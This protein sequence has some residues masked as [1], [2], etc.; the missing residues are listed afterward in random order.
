MSSEGILSVTGWWPDRIPTGTQKMWTGGVAVQHS[1]TSSSMD[2]VPSSK[3]PETPTCSPGA[4]LQLAIA[5]GMPVCIC[6]PAPGWVKSREN[7]FPQKGKIKDYFNLTQVMFG[8][9]PDSL[10][11]GRSSPFGWTRAIVS[12][13]YLMRKRKHCRGVGS[14]RYGL[15]CTIMNNMGE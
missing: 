14:R 8:Y 13:L 11:E 9:K 15:S 1:P 12:S 4:A 2:V 3:A 10:L 5:P 7:N 6:S